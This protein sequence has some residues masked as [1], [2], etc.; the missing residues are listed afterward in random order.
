VKQ[1]EDTEKVEAIIDLRNFEKRELPDLGKIKDIQQYTL[2]LPLDELFYYTYL[3]GKH[4][5]DFSDWFVDHA[6]FVEALSNELCK[7][8]PIK[9]IEVIFP[10]GTKVIFKTW[11]E[12][13]DK[14][15][16]VTAD[17]IRKL[18]K[19]YREM[20]NPSTKPETTG[21]ESS[22]EEVAEETTTQ[23]TTKQLVVNME[24][25]TKLNM[26]LLEL[27]GFAAMVEQCGDR[28]PMKLVTYAREAEV[29]IKALESG[30]P[31]VPVN[32]DPL[33]K[34]LNAN[35]SEAAQ[36]GRA[37][38]EAAAEEVFEPK[39]KRSRKG[40]NT[41]AFADVLP[42]PGHCPKRDDLLLVPDGVNGVLE[43]LEQVTS[44]PVKD[45]EEAE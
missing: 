8:G 20:R 28:V 26:A 6:G 27:R 4:F 2:T 1:K 22:E 37:A 45:D 42:R 12:M 33:D 24:L 39:P 40:R 36:L 16:G 23:E 18:I 5:Q 9:P 17:W 15:F 41:S 38:G 19:N 31:V 43:E 13:C 3:I 30:V 7:K 10:D 14:L 35:N 25:V 11:A 29:R 44:K 21:Q 32:S 34:L